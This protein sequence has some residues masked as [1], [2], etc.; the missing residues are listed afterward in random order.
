MGAE[1]SATPPLGPLLMICCS[2]FVE[3]TAFTQLVRTRASTSRRLPRSE[4]RR[5]RRVD[6]RRLRLLLVLQRR[7]PGVGA[8]RDAPRR[9]P[10]RGGR[11]AL[12]ACCEVGFG[13][14][15][16]LGAAVA[17][18]PAHGLCSG[19]WAML[20]AH[21]HSIV[22]DSN[23]VASFGFFSATYSLATCLGPL[24]GAALYGRR[25][26]LL[27]GPGHASPA[28][29][30][31]EVLALASLCVIPALLYF[32]RRDDP[33]K[34]GGAGAPAAAAAARARRRG[35]VAA[36]VR[37]ARRAAT[38]IQAAEAAE[39]A[40]ARRRRAPPRLGDLWR[41]RAH[42][43]RPRLPRALHR[44]HEL[45]GRAAALGAHPRGAAARR[46][47]TSREVGLSCAR[48]AP[49]RRCTCS[50]SSGIQRAGAAVL[51]GR[52]RCRWSARRAAARAPRARRA[53]RRTRRGGGGGAAR[54][55]ARR[56][57]RVRGVPGLARD[58]AALRACPFPPDRCPTFF[59]HPSA[60]V[61]QVSLAR[62]RLVLPRRRDLHQQPVEDE[63]LTPLAARSRR[64]APAS[65][66]VRPALCAAA[67]SA[68]HAA[69]ARAPL[70][71]PTFGAPARS[72]CSRC[73]ASRPSAAR[74]SPS[75]E[76]HARR[77]E[78]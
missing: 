28:A 48:A 31:C 1:C 36:D 29:A 5:H 11:A 51:G 20:Q 8:D 65:R 9:G 35:G 4:R 56:R 50:R 40:D 68:S 53:R 16:T 43:R 25:L 22:D 39:A 38:T 14:A 59:L 41:N 33:R 70:S 60:R 7:E 13:R 69:S 44:L 26:T 62:A 63:R 72:S 47:P 19:N 21:L 17:W 12:Q 55:R 58:A 27:A 3:T 52:G 32:V 42:T 49:R 64:R 78:E 76:R 30:P 73:C 66:A 57:E 45:G 34:S 18:R 77:A 46:G 10:H 15:P 37:R 67:F 2:V 54:A 23:Q 24:F 61:S 71:G 75:V 74:S 6:G